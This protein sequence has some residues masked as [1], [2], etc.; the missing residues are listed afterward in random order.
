MLELALLLRL[1]DLILRLAGVIL[2][3]LGVVSDHVSE[4]LAQ[5]IEIQLLHDQR[6]LPLV[7]LM[8]L[9]AVHIPDCSEELGLLL[10]QSGQLVALPLVLHR[11]SLRLAVLNTHFEDLESQFG[12][13]LTVHVNVGILMNRD[14]LMVWLEDALDH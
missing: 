13:L 11:A 7:A 14:D 6:R 1:L 3:N 9:N 4:G 2:G 12:V 8:R 10:N 5:E